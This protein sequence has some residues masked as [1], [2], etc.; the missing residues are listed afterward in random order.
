MVAKKKKCEQ[1]IHFQIEYWKIQ[2]TTVINLESIKKNSQT[3]QNCEGYETISLR[4]LQFSSFIAS[5]EP[6]DT[7]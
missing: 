3:W 6:A 5:S 1:L 4:G 7:V 2:N